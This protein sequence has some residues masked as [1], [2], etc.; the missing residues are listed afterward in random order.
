MLRM[1]DFDD[2]DE[3]IQEVSKNQQMFLKLQQLTSLVQG[4][5]PIIAETTGDT[6]IMDMF[7]DASAAAS[8][9][10]SGAERK[11]STNQLGEVT[12]EDEN[13]QAAKMREETNNRAAVGGAK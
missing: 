6:R 7:P 13:S 1:M 10:G 4:L 2:K 3:I 12:K 8:Q 11:L 9:P 5:G